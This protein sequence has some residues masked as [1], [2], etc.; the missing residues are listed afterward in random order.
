MW[1]DKHRLYANLVALY[2]N[3]MNICGFRYLGSWNESLCISRKEPVFEKYEVTLKS[4]LKANV[5][6]MSSATRMK[7]HCI[8]FLS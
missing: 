4:A 6:S 5:G 2:I 3:D 8:D 1:E 7:N